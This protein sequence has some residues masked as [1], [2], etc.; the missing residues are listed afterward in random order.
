MPEEF[1]FDAEGVIMDDVVMRCAQ[2][3]NRN[4]GR[5]GRSKN[6]IFSDDRGRC[7]LRSQPNLLRVL[8]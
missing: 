8:H 6:V 3:T 5:S 7:A 1:V 4:Q 2:G